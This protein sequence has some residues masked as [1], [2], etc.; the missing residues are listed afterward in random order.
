IIVIAHRLTSL[1]HASEILF[2][3]EGR[4]LERG[5]HAEL[6]ALNGRYAALYR[7]QTTQAGIEE[8]DPE[9]AL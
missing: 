9:T 4:I 8:L 7:L 3:E 2:L 5:N 1:M 6:I